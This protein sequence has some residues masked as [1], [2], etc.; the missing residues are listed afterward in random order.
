MDNAHN[1][2][3]GKTEQNTFTDEQKEKIITS[4][5]ERAN[6]AITDLETVAEDLAAGYSFLIAYMRANIRLE[7]FAKK[8]S[9]LTEGDVI[10]KDLLTEAAELA[11]ETTVQLVKAPSASDE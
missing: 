8:V 4:M 6:L 11:K 2:Y 1:P 10:S 3:T 5:I 9:G 7:R